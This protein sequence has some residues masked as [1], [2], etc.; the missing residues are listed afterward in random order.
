[1]KQETVHIAVHRFEDTVYYR[2]LAAEDYRLL[3][4]L[5]QGVTLGDAIDIAFNGS[6]IPENE[7]PAYLQSA[8]AYWTSMG[9]FCTPPS[10]QEG[11]ENS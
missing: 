6:L 10:D 9:W 11:K 2:R 3:Q 8:F 7:R 4:A 1:M 5:Q